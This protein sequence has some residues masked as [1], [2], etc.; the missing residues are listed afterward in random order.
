[1]NYGK[2][3]LDAIKQ[4]FDEIGKGD[5]KFIINTSVPILKLREGDN[6]IRILPPTASRTGQ[7]FGLKIYV[8]NTVGINKDSFLCVDKMDWIRNKTDLIKCIICSEGRKAKVAGASDEE[9]REFIPYRKFLF[10][11]VDMDKPHEGIKVWIAPSSVVDDIMILC[12]DKRTKSFKDI[13]SPQNGQ[14]IYITREGQGVRTKYKGI[15]LEDPSPIARPEWLDQM[16]ELENILIIPT[17][18]DFETLFGNENVTVESVPTPS[19]EESI[20]SEP[21]VPESISDR[22]RQRMRERFGDK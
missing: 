20:T 10:N 15:Q 6:C 16:Y 21:S 5:R 22:I 17:K 9:I 3:S 11:V 4:V 18:K 14:N 8:H 19:E 7:F 1:M 2:T 12:L 13:S